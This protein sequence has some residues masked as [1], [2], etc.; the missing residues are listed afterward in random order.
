MKYNVSTW[1]L[2]DLVKDKQDLEHIVDVIKHDTNK[3]K[4]MYTKLKLDIT[5]NDFLKILNILENIYKNINIINTFV[6][7][8]Y[9]TDTQSDEKTL[10]VN[11]IKKL[12]ADI[13][14][15][16]LYFDLWWTKVNNKTAMR[17]IKNANSRIFDTKKKLTQIHIK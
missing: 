16:L 1:N 4:S 14:N 13:S 11:Q 3:L 6:S 10:L 2:N 17:L 8:S 5:S 15:E 12:T 9:V 7:L